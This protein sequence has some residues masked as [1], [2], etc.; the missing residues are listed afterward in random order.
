[1]C[2]SAPESYSDLQALLRGHSSEQ[3][4][5][6]LDRTVKCHHPSLATGNKAKLQVR[7]QSEPRATINGWM[8]TQ[9]EIYREKIVHSSVFI[10]VFINTLNSFSFLY[11]QF[12]FKV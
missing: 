6:I 7:D 11:F 4:R 5:L 2:V 1:M 12:N 3:Q 10:I 8:E 9:L